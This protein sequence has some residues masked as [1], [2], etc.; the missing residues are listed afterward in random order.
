[1]K[2]KN[3]GESAAAD[4]DLVLRTRS[5]DVDAFGE[6]WRRHC[7]SGMTV[8]RSITSSIDADDLVQEAYSRIY[9]AIL[10]GGGP[11]GSFRA[12]LFTSI[13]NTAA[14]W[15]RR[16]RETT[17]DELETVVD[18]AS[19]DAAVSEELDR[20]LTAKAFRSLPSRW[21][22]VLWYSEIEQMKPAA[23][24]TLLGMSAGAVSQLSFRAREG[25]REAWIQAHLHSVGE[26]S[27][28]Q[29]TIERLG[30]YARG[31]LTTRAHQRVD[32]HLEGCA[33]CMIV[34]AEAKDVSSRLTLVLLPLVLGVTG[35]SAYLASLQLGEAPVAALAA[36][37]SSVVEGVVVASAT[38][39][40]GVAAAT[41]TTGASSSAA[42][43]GSAG[44]S[45]GVVSG[46]GAL[47][48]AGSAALVIAG[49]VAAAAVLPGV[50]GGAPATSQPN[51][52]ESDSSSVAS[53][54]VAPA[55]GLS[56]GDPL[57]IDLPEQPTP[58]PE[59]KTDP[60]ADVQAPP[61]S[62]PVTVADEPA[63]PAPDPTA[64]PTPAETTEPS[65]E[66]GTTDPGTTDPGTT[67]PGT[68][69]PITASTFTVS[70]DA[71]LTTH[72]SVPIQGEPGA[73]VRAWMDDA[74]G[75]GDEIAL[76]GT[77]GGVIDL[78]PS[79]TQ[80]LI[81]ADLT[82]TYLVDGVPG[83]STRYWIVPTLL[84]GSGGSTPGSAAPATDTTTPTDTTP[85]DATATTDATTPTDAASTTE[86]APT[87]T[88][89][90]ASA[91][92]GDPSA[93]PTTTATTTEPISAPAPAETV[94]PTTTTAPAD[95]T[96]T[97]D[98]TAPTDPAPTTVS[99]E[100]VAATSPAT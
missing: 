36:M 42:A 6:L 56:T 63:P 65:I 59:P 43:G 34:A 72:Y 99:S 87:S 26:G 51:A 17:I 88:T 81:G 23:I 50:L 70:I 69:A 44:S 8:A 15:G 24:G 37:P 83:S 84:G 18:P 47:V 61:A 53:A 9:Q 21:Q 82:L 31:N 85:T 16:R 77:G 4:A 39:S 74:P 1:M 28:C 54:D 52:S 62:A 40:A 98:T 55:P 10:T 76:D 64:E 67:D 22:E 60:D 32:D 27:E 33:R 46:I 29:W 90:E 89:T 57:V 2:E 91:P 95:T 80:M 20:G 11:N 79:L 7:R 75:G 100:P 49:V 94:D 45:A 48:G 25:L 38:G 66:P 97:S 96:V 86:T 35:A 30:A 93:S 13:R 14:A 41:G 3:P 73:T 78:R 5:G 68:M 92:T 19:T 71:S 58:A 12:Y